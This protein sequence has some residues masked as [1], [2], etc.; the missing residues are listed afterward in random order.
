MDFWKIKLFK[1]NEGIENVSF[2]INLWYRLFCKLNCVKK[3]KEIKV[4]KLI[5]TN[6]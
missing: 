5:L 2:K 6:A 4:I 3:D 1:I